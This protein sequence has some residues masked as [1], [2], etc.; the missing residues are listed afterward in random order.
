MDKET[1]EIIQLWHAARI[2]YSLLPNDIASAVMG[3]TIG[4]W[5]V[6]CESL[7]DFYNK[8]LFTFACHLDSC[9]IRLYSIDEK[10]N[11][12]RYK[13]YQDWWQNK[14]KGRIHF[15]KKNTGRIIHCVLR[16]KVGH[17]E[18]KGKDKEGK[19]SYQE[20]ESYYNSLT[21]QELFDGMKDVINSI[22]LDLK[23][24]ANGEKIEVDSFA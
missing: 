5:S 24:G 18:C 20:L 15:F 10:R 11:H 19:R 16:N 1:R 17:D 13:D 4:N 12:Q 22:A 3:K 23:Q 2:Y 14:Q 21:F 9:A 7:N 6:E 8:P